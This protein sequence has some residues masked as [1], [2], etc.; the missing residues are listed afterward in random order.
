MASGKVWLQVRGGYER[1][2]KVNE[3]MWFQEI[4]NG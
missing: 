4:E 3:H 1:A 2:S